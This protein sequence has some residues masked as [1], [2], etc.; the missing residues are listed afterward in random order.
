M[1]YTFLCIHIF[2]FSVANQSFFNVN[3]TTGNCCILSNQIL[4]NDGKWKDVPGGGIHALKDLAE[5]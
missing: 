2:I 1:L 5:P 4:K 3:W